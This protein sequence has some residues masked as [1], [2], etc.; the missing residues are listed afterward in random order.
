[1]WSPDRRTLL[2]LAAALPAAL[3]G[4]CGFRPM[5]GEGSPSRAIVGRV[6]VMTVPDGDGYIMRDRL[7]QLLGSPVAASHMV[8]V[9]I[10]IVTE[11]VALT[12]SDITT[13]YAIV[14][15]AR[16][17]LV[18]VS[19]GPP[20]LVDEVRAIAGY[21]SPESEI[22]A[23]FASRAAE[24]NTRE[25]VVLTLADRIADRLAVTAGDWAA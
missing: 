22:S 10:D 14:G 9:D 17:R 16:F 12:E 1:M 11:G 2:R 21:S 7:V 25:R 4:G 5:Y 19:G 23:A 13:R 15:T 6:E 3:A 20:V 18:P 8:D 24:R